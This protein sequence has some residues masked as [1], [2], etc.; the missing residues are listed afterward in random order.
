MKRAPWGFILVVV[1]RFHPCF[2]CLILILYRFFHKVRCE[3]GCCQLIFLESVFCLQ[4]YPKSN[5]LPGCAARIQ[6][7]KTL[8]CLASSAAM[9]HPA[10]RRFP[11]PPRWLKPG[12]GRPGMWITCIHVDPMGGMGW[13]VVP[14]GDGVGHRFANV[15]E[16]HNTTRVRDDFCKSVACAWSQKTLSFTD[17][18]NG[19]GHIL[20]WLKFV[21]NSLPHHKSAQ[22]KSPS[23]AMLQMM[24]AQDED[25]ME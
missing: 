13:V 2:F 23:K 17:T 14:V 3:K 20:D 22:F 11:Q 18:T 19:I 12:P 7:S 5:Y 1:Y 16:W 25:P 24:E 10:T 21:S 8:G 6:V 4:S 9:P 15:V